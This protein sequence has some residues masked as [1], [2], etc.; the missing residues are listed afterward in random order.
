MSTGRALRVELM[1]HN[2]DT[3][4]RKMP[5]YSCLPTSLANCMIQGF[6][7]G[8]GGKGVITFIS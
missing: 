2:I 3:P 6:T 5:L 8:K 7:G 4:I 1:S